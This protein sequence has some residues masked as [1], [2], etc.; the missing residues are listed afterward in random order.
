[1]TNGYMQDKNKFIEFS[2]N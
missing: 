1:M 2:V